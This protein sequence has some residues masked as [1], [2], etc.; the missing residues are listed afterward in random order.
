[1]DLNSGKNYVFYKFLQKF[2]KSKNFLYYY[3]KE[4]IYSGF[5]ESAG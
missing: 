2:Q 3:A 5:S 1:M 4:M